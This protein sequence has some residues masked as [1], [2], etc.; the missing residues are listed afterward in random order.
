MSNLI[1]RLRSAKTF[2]PSQFEL[3]RTANEAADVMTAMLAALSAAETVREAHTA[4]DRLRVSEG[5]DLVRVDVPGH[6]AYWLTTEQRDVVRTLLDAA[7][8]SRSPEVNGPALSRAAGR[9]GVRLSEVFAG[10]PAW[11]KLVV[12][13]TQAGHY[14]LCDL[15]GVDE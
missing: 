4:R 1:E 12:R 13:G 8:N 5:R 14:R 15:P 6:D 9:P 10:S 2:T 11:G 3:A 7:L